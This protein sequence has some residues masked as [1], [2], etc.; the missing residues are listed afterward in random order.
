MKNV[1]CPACKGILKHRHR[2]KMFNPW[3]HKCPLC[4]AVLETTGSR[5]IMT[6]ASALLGCLTVCFAFF[7]E[8]TGK[9]VFTDSLVFFAIAL[10]VVIIFSFVLWPFAKFKIKENA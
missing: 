6:F 5:K 4:G 7:M 10:V 2:L 3:K 8:E 1:K 9:W